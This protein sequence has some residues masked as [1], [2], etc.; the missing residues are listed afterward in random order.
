MNKFLAGMALTAVLVVPASAAAKPND[1]E[2]RAARAECKAERGDTKA[3][4][5]AFKSLYGSFGRCVR[6]K[7]AEEEAENQAARESAAQE[8]KDERDA[9]A[10][11]FGQTYGTNKN[12]KNAFGR[13][14]SGKAS[15]KKAEL[16]AADAQQT[17]ERHSAAKDCA[18]ERKSSGVEAFRA[19]YGTNRNDRNAFGKCVSAK[20]DAA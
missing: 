5:K 13:C 1:T 11:L 9:N 20:T 17:A 4:R 10:D 16:D 14:V 7:A 8:C 2:K 15:Q 3:E 19:Q 6:E 18:D 12:G